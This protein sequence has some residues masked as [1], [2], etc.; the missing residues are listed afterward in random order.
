MV[1]LIAARAL[2]GVGAGAIIPLSMTIIGELYTSEHYAAGGFSGV[3]GVASIAGRSSDT[4][5]TISWRW[6]FYLN[7]PF[8]LLALVN[9]AA[10]QSTGNRR[11]QG[12]LAGR[13]L[14]VLRRQR[15]LALGGDTSASVA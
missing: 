5:P 4:S 15:L 6:V 7:L 11:R 10:Y 9:R 12:G 1:Q 13:A 3:W 2:Q 14:H 8:G